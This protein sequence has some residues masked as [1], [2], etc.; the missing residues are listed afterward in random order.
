MLQPVD[1]RVKVNVTLPAVTPLTTPALVTVAIEVLL[2]V[3][4]P[5][6]LGDKF[7]VLP[8]HTAAGAVTTGN[9]LTVTEDV[10]LLHP[11]DVCVKVKVTLPAAMPVTKP[12]FVTEAIEVLL[13]VQVPPVVGDKVIAFPTHTA[14]GEFTTGSSSTVTLTVPAVLVHRLTV[15]VTLYKP[16]APF[17]ALVIAGFC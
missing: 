2:L 10:V 6:V 16:A 12:A 4:V 1:V 15:A 14:G 7:M 5:P 11:V 17:V 13:L 8:I 9:A 3:Q